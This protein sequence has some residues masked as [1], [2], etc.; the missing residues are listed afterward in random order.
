ML[1]LI[2][3]MNLN[4]SSLTHSSCASLFTVHIMVTLSYTN[5][6]VSS[7]L[8]FS[9]KRT[10]LICHHPKLSGH[11]QSFHFVFVQDSEDS[12]S[13]PA[14]CPR[15]E[16]TGGLHEQPGGLKT[17]RDVARSPA[18]TLQTGSVRELLIRNHGCWMDRHTHRR[19]Q[20]RRPWDPLMAPPS[21]VT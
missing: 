2:I 4:Y 12:L 13:H 9:A 17:C 16:W 18:R 8:V 14:S 11:L 1:S 15:T 3:W 10:C 5:C 20:K 21:Q 7:T 6:H 19:E